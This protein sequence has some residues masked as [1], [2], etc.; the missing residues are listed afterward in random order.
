MH[1]T[2]FHQSKRCLVNMNLIDD[3]LNRKCYKITDKNDMK[4]DGMLE[5]IN[6][7]S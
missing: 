6:S 3:I 5:K 1:Y 7:T 2:L 4:F